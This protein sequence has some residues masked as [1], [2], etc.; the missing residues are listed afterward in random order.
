MRF[1]N[2]DR[3]RAGAAGFRC[4]DC[5]RSRAGKNQDPNAVVLTLAA[6]HVIWTRSF[7]CKPARRAGSRRRGHIVTFGIT[8][9]KPKTS[10]GYI[11]R[12]KPLGPKEPIRSRSSSRSRTPPPPHA[13]SRKAIS[14]IPEISCSAPDVLLAELMRLEPRL[15]RSCRSF[16]ACWP[17]LISTSCGSTPMPSPCA[18]QKSIDYALMEKTERAAVVEAR[19]TLVRYRKLGRRL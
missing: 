14:G 12:G 5:G 15:G 18:P 10:Y 8:P 19:Y 9:T 1:R 13:T 3:D 7:L 2:D 17:K 16:G 4:C 6:D 11:L